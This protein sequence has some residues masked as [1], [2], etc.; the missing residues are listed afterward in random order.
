METILAFVAVA[1]LIGVTVWRSFARERLRSNRLAALAPHLGFSTVKENTKYAFG[2]P[3]FYK[4]ETGKNLIRNAMEGMVAGLP[5]MVFDLRYD[6]NSGGEEGT[7]STWRTVAAFSFPNGDFPSFTITRSGFLARRAADKVEIAGNPEFSER[8][9]VNGKNKEAIQT[10]LNAGVVQ[11]LVSARASDNLVV[12]GAGT[13]LVLYRKG[14][15]IRPQQWKEFL[16]E[17]SLI[18][19]GFAQNCGTLSAAPGIQ[20]QV[21][22]AP[23]RAQAS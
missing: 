15:R 10:L 18:A 20:V 1:M 9:V 17:T 11:S 16:D 7:S 6:V 8:F 3:L 5:A 12:E 22:I 13:W 21:T 23:A 19:A 14:R 4:G 2:T